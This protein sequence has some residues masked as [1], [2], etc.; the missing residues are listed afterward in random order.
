MALK[1][2][3]T[4]VDE[5][6]ANLKEAMKESEERTFRGMLEAAVFIQG[7]AQEITPHAKKNGGTLLGSAFH[8][9]D[10]DQM[11]AR[12]GYTADYAAYVHEMPD[13]SLRTGKSVNWSKEGTGNKFLEKAVM[14][15]M[16]AIL[17]KIW[18]RGRFE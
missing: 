15:N 4:A 11:A 18:G 8:D 7:E 3:Q 10:R 13:P 16:E 12:V 14:N 6:N 2:I 9:S 5:I 17:T 1:N